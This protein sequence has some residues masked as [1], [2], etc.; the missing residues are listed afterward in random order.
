M[1]GK[2]RAISTE[3]NR[4]QC[5][6]VLYHSTKPMRA[7]EVARQLE[8]EPKAAGTAL[9]FAY[10]DGS[11]SRMQLPGSQFHAYFMTT[12]QMGDMRMLDSGVLV[13]RYVLKAEPIDIT[14]RMLFLRKLADNPFWQ[15]HAELH[16]IIADYKRTLNAQN[17]LIDMEEKEAA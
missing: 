3:S 5:M 1:M 16:N 14:A 12:E 8:L 9:Q 17:S 2:P 10:Q 15:E 6:N 13:R 7:F 4:M 11:I